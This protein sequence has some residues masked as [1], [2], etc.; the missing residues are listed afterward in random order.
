MQVEGCRVVAGIFKVVAFGLILAVWVLVLPSHGEEEVHWAYSGEHGP[1]HWA[2][3]SEAFVACGVGLNQ[4]PIDIVNPIEAELAPIQ[5][6]HRGSTTSLVNNGHTLQVNVQPGSW[7]T[8]EGLKFELLQFHFHS[9][10]EHRIQGESFPLEAHLVHRNQ[11]SELAVVAI[12]FRYG[13]PNRSLTAIAASASFEI[14]KVVPL[15]I[16]LEDLATAPPQ[17]RYYRYSGSPTTPPC[18]EGVRWYVLESTR[19]VSRE[20]VSYFVDLIGE[21]ARGPQPLNARLVLH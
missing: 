3:L 9:P 4:S 16:A 18:T 10:S 7:L 11:R 15:K 20:Q 1:E 6:S 14:A 21:D 12:L 8:A 2:E 13:E 17:E 19:S 5:R